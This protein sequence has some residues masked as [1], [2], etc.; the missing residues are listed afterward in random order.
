[1]KKIVII[2][3]KLS[4]LFSVQHACETVGFTPIISSDKNDLKDADGIILP[5][6]GAFGDAMENLDKLGLIEPIIEFANSSKPLMGICLGLQLL[7]SESEEFGSKKGLGLIQGYVKKFPPNIANDR[8]KVP[9]IGWNRIYR[10]ENSCEWRK[11]PLAG[12][13][14]DE[15]MYF[16]HSYFVCPDEKE[17][18][19]SL[20]N[21]AGIEFCSGIQKGNIFATQFHPEKSAKEGLKIY[22]NWITK[23]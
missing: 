7:F 11:S 9:H 20:T 18:I 23:L 22:Y 16:V 5:G 12:L 2:D 4:N 19:L 17:E 8:I 3:Y 13:S 10:P 14:A 21:Y 1:M 6:V 15:Y